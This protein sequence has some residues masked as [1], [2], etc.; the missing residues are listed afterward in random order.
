LQ[1]L[2]KHADLALYTSKH[3]GRDRVTCHGAVGARDTSL[4]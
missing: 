2:L 4:A 3:A 1:Q